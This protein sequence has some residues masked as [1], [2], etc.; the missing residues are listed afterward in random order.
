MNCFGIRREEKESR[1][2]KKWTVCGKTKA[3]GEGEE[4]VFGE[5]PGWTLCLMCG[6]MTYWLA[7]LWTLILL[8]KRFFGYEPH[9][10]V[11]LAQH[12]SSAT[13]THTQAHTLLT[14]R[15]GPAS[16]NP[17]LRCVYSGVQ[18]GASV[19]RTQHVLTLRYNL[20][21]RQSARD[22]VMLGKEVYTRGSKRELNPH[23]LIVIVKK[24]SIVKCLR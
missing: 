14:L 2:R 18:P 10:G 11:T 7:A 17:L 4:G 16:S 23:V 13:H 20:L 6:G 1:R 12:N 24:R 19:W 5:A 9:K 3:K 8:S 22:K 21:L 15:S